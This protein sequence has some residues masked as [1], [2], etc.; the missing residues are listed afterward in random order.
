MSSNEP[1]DYVLTIKKPDGTTWASE[2]GILPAI[3]TKKATQ[4]TGH[5]TAELTASYCGSSFHASTS[6]SVV[7]ATY[8]VTISLSGLPNDLKTT[9]LVDGKK[10]AEMNGQGVGE[11]IRLPGVRP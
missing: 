8:D 6:F 10:V 3:F 2:S 9:L 4:P 11:W 5:Y 7:L 1:A